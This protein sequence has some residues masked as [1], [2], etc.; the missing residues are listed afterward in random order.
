VGS[1]WGIERNKNLVTTTKEAI[2]FGLVGAR[3]IDALCVCLDFS[4]LIER[5]TKTLGSHGR[6]SRLATVVSGRFLLDLLLAGWLAAER[7]QDYVL[8]VQFGNKVDKVLNYHLVLIQFF[9]SSGI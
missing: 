7:S 3:R 1:C 6:C 8:L 4:R 2:V 9:S 5:D